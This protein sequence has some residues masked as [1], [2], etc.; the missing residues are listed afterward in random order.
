MALVPYEPFR[1]LDHFRREWDQ[2]FNDW[3]SFFK[4]G[5]SGRIDIDLYETE[6]EVVAACDIPGLEK[7]EDVNIDIENNVLTISG[8]LNRTHEVKEENMHRK[9]RFF[10]RFHRSVSLPSAV[11]S[12]GVTAT[13]RNGVLEIRMPKLKGDTKKRIDIQF[14]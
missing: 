5:M 2:F 4:Q 12:E 6:N 10:G 13:Y 7:K 9:E 1:N 3:P 8:S 14:H 11:S